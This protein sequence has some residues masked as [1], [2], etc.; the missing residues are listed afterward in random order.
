[1]S[2]LLVLHSDQILGK[3]KLWHENFKLSIQDCQIFTS[4]SM[5]IVHSIFLKTMDLWP[6]RPQIMA[7][8]SLLTNLVE[9][10]NLESS[11]VPKTEF[12]PSPERLLV[13]FLIS[14][15][16]NL[17]LSTWSGIFVNYQNSIIYCDFHVGVGLHIGALFHT[18]LLCFMGIWRLI[19]LQQVES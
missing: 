19:L 8:W 2:H 12:G 1:M 13:N 6:M 18:Q 15:H 11:T 5:S 17:M 10:S 7:E 9:L 4:R 3:I 16:K 14:R